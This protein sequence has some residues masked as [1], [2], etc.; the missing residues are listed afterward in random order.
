MTE[1][2]FQ[3]K[4]PSGKNNKSISRSA[5][6]RFKRAILEALQSKEMTHTELVA[7]VE[8]DLD[9][10]FDGNVSWNVMVVKLDLEARG[11]IERVGS[12]PQKYRVT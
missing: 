9:G 2:M 12:G 1:E 5:Y 10:S 3:T 7:Q 11:I 8:K 6:D 4:H